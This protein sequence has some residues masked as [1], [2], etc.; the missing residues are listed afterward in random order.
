MIFSVTTSIVS[1]AVN[2]DLTDL[3]TAKNELCISSP[4]NDVWLGQAISQVSRSIA[5]YVKRV[6]VPEVVQDQFDIQLQRPSSSLRG[7]EELQLTRW[8]VLSVVSVVQKLSDGSALTLVEGT[9][10]RVNTATGT[11]LRLNSSGFGS[12]WEVLPVT[13]TYMA[14]YGTKVLEVAVVPA[15]PYKVTVAQSA[16]FSCDQSVSYANG[17]KLVQV[18]ASPA[19]GQYSITAGVY[20]FAAADTGQSLTIVYGV[21]NAPAD[22]VEACLRLVNARFRSKDRDPSLVQQETP[23]VGVQ[24]WWVGGTPG[25]HSPFAPDIEHI[26]DPYIMPVMA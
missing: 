21:K 18:A 5:S 11:L 13:V 22:L 15:S 17:N 16:A 1:A 2:Y 23:G 4:A 12:V 14:G 19:T 10:Y 25:Q 3:Y 24:R 26:L 6:L 9:D 20:T 7:D 8:P